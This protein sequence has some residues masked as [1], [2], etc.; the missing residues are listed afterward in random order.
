MD[1]F[2]KLREQL[3]AKSLNGA[4]KEKLTAETIQKAMRIIRDIPPK[5]SIEH[6]EAINK[7]MTDDRIKEFRESILKPPP[8]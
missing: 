3:L 7:F 4:P 1:D 2:D 5:V 8:E 6:I